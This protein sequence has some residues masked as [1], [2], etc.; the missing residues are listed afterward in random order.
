MT[1]DGKFRLHDGPGPIARLPQGKVG[2]RIARCKDSSISL[3]LKVADDSQ[4]LHR[5]WKKR[6]YESSGW[7]AALWALLWHRTGTTMLRHLGCFFYIFST[8]ARD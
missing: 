1:S 3:F 7:V 5:G 8:F 2:V 6:L 4:R